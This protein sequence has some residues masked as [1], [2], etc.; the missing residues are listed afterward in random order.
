MM[1]QQAGERNAGQPFEASCRNHVLQQMQ[2]AAPALGT[3][4]PIPVRFHHQILLLPRLLAACF[5]PYLNPLHLPSAGVCPSQTAALFPASRAVWLCTHLV[6]PTLSAS[7]EQQNPRSPEMEQLSLIF[8]TYTDFCASSAFVFHISHHPA[9][10][11]SSSQS[12]QHQAILGGKRKTFQE[13]LKFTFG[14]NKAS[15]SEIFQR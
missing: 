6:P 15:S 10:R 4:T 12:H 3:V 8:L 13:S 5:P 2:A 7:P 1:K 11:G 9:M 14:L